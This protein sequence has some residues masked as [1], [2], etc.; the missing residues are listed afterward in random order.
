M[1][2]LWHLNHFH[3]LMQATAKKQYKEKV[4]PM[5]PAIERAAKEKDF[6]TRLFAVLVLGHLGPDARASQQPGGFF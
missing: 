5:L 3:S 6:E 2:A 4:L 1:L